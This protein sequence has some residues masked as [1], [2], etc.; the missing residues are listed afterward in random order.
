MEIY[1]YRH[2]G[3]KYL[4]GTLQSRYTILKY[5]N[6]FETAFIKSFDEGI[7]LTM[8]GKD[9]LIPYP[10]Y[11]KKDT[12]S[13]DDEKFEYLPWVDEEISQT[14]DAR[15]YTATTDNTT[16]TT[17]YTPYTATAQTGFPTVDSVVTQPPR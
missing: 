13:L 9:S 7:F 4:I 3:G 11:T 8:D 12:K 17:Y 5:I 10:L 16:N 1:H 6:E 15:I 14:P 2:L